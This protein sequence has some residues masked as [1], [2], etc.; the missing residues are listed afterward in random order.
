MDQGGRVELS[1]KISGFSKTLGGAYSRNSRGGGFERQ[2]AKMPSDKVLAGRG[3]EK[4]R[5]FC[6]NRAGREL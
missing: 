6:L 2:G 1:Q 4:R 5:Y 3:L